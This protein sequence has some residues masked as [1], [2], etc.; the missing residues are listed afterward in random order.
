MKL[1]NLIKELDKPEKIYVDDSEETDLSSL[2]AKQKRDLYKQGSL[3]IPT[4]D[5]SKPNVTSASK[6]VYA[7][8]FDK[9]KKNLVDD[10]KSIAIYQYHDKNE[11]KDLTIKLIDVYN[12]MWKAIDK[13]DKMVQLENK[14]E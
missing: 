13:L 1:I 4:S 10:K 2:T 6:V 11:I 7:S 12:K 3:L 5:P 8:D 14:K 9:I